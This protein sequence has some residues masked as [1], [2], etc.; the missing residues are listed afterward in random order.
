MFKVKFLQ[1]IPAAFARRVRLGRRGGIAVMTA[2]SLP[3]LVAIGGF[4]V[5]V[6]IWDGQQTALQAA[7]DAGA[8]KAARDLAENPATTQATLEADAIAAANAASQNQFSLNASDLTTSQ[9][10]DAR[11][12]QVSASVPAQHFFSQ[13]LFPMPVTIGAS[14]TAGIAYST[15][16]TQATC[17]AADSY[18]Y[19]YS[20]GVGAIDTSHSAGIDPYQCG[21]PPSA[22]AAYDAFCGGGILGCPLNLLGLG[23]DLLPFAFQ[24]GPTG[25][26]GGVGPVL[27]TTLDTVGNVAQTLVSLLGGSAGLGSGTPLVLNQ[28]SPACPGNVCTIAAG[29]YNGG[30]TFGPGLT[31]DF[32]ASGANNVFFIEN[33]NLVINNQDTLGNTDPSALFFLGGSNPGAYVAATQVQINTAPINSGAIVLTSQATFYSDSLVGTQT[34]APMSSMPAAQ[35]DELNASL[36]SP[37][38]APTGLVAGTNFYSV[39]GVCPLATSTCTN[40]ET[41]APQDQFTVVPSLGIIASL[42]PSLTSNVALLDMLSNEGE[43]SVTTITSGVTFGNGVP[44][45]WSQSESA[46]NTLTNTVQQVSKVLASMG[47]PSLLT[48][49]VQGILNLISPN[50]SSSQSFA[51]SGVFT[52]QTSIATPSCNGQ[53]VLYQKPITPGFGPGFTDILDVAGEGAATGNVAVT[54]TVTVCGNATVASIT[55]IM[56][57]TMLVSSTAGGASTLMLLR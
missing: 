23:G 55:P 7:A 14:S 10:K 37:L 26:P 53:T 28:G 31:I 16:S 30:I 33:G 22:P 21:S 39:I 38:G 9:L 1:I 2:L 49:P 48:A 6:G 4:T 20:T 40:P 32:V 42:L 24:I 43:T 19:L 44:T 51:D 25:G 17:Y 47:L 41:Q 13:V 45:N 29:I 15:V 8:V 11:Q 57:G 34:S 5:D 50:E 56:P 46:N 35:Q 3:M 54:D 27:G 36:L 52:G 18:T 12:I